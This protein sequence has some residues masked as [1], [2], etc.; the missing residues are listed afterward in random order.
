MESQEKLNAILEYADDMKAERIETLDV[1]AKTTVAH[2]FVVCTG[3]SDVHVRA[4]AER[5][6]EKMRENHKIKPL[7]TEAGDASWVLQDFGDVVFN[8]MR[9]EK[10]QFY[11]LESLWNTMAPDSSLIVE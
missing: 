11:D 3:T 8:V 9:D 7:R 4:I 10:R 5:V 1:H 2:Y 6:A